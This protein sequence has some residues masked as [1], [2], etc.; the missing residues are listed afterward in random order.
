MAR[1][2][3]SE[4]DLDEILTSIMTEGKRE[5]AENLL[6]TEHEH[7]SPVH[8]G[9]R[10]LQPHE[11][12]FMKK[13]SY[14]DFELHVARF[15]AE[16]DSVTEADLQFKRTSKFP[17]PFCNRNGRLTRKL[18]KFLSARYY[19]NGVEV[20][21]GENG[22]KQIHYFVLSSSVVW[23]A[24]TPFEEWESECSLYDEPYSSGVTDPDHTTI[25][26]DFII[27][28]YHRHMA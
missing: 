11:K 25:R 5:H 1:A 9:G 28:R 17:S 12:F 3:L 2:L 21:D 18:R 8:P 15:L 26:N 24:S 20:A 23:R 4:R 27:L 7:C 22:G 13:Y 19:E 16:V 10:G 14:G 6:Q